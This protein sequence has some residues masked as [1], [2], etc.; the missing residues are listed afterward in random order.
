[1]I[2]DLSTFYFIY[3]SVVNSFS[4]YGIYVF[5]F[6][7]SFGGFCYFYIYFC[8]KRAVHGPSV[9]N[10]LQYYSRALLW[11]YVIA[12]IVIIQR[13]FAGG[14]LRLTYHITFAT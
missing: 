9:G 8:F 13:P 2:R 12:L 1:M 5:S 11:D 4:C 10:V 7:G 14:V 3:Y 6:I